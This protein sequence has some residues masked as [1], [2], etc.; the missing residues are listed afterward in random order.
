MLRAI[1]EDLL[2]SK[3]LAYLSL[4]NEL[5]SHLA[6]MNHYKRIFNEERGLLLRLCRFIRDSFP[7]VCNKHELAFGY[8][9]FLVSLIID[10]KDEAYEKERHK[11]DIDRAEFR[12]LEEINKQFGGMRVDGNNTER[13][14]EAFIAESG[15]RAYL[16][17]EVRVQ[18]LLAAFFKQKQSI[19]ERDEKVFEVRAQPD[20]RKRSCGSCGPCRRTRSSPTCCSS[21]RFWR[22]PSESTGK[23][24]ESKSTSRSTIWRTT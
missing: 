24:K 7:E 22:W 11:L 19:L 2:A 8:M 6:T 18:N 3:K 5:F 10:V 12:A 13:Y 16:I 23:R 1:F 20:C 4:M 14:D 15:V 17:R 21:T 9:N